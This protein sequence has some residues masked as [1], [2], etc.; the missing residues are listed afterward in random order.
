MS[1][2]TLKDLKHIPGSNGLPFL[3]Q[4]I[5][6]V[7]NATKF[8]SDQQKRHGD[9]FKY[10]TPMGTAVVLLGPT[11]NKYVLVEQ[12]KFA[13]NKEAWEQS[14][15]DLFPNG[16]ML[17]DGDKH[18]SHRSI[19]NEAFKKDPMQGYLKMMPEIIDRELVHLNGKSKALMF[20]FFKEFT[21]KMAAAIFFGLD[22][23]EDLKGIN[24][25]LTDIVNAAAVLP[26]NLPG[27]AYRKGLN[28]RKYLVSYFTS[29]IG[30]R[31][32]NP[33]S[34][35]FSRFCEA[36]SEEGETFTDQEIIDHLIFVLMAAHDT[37][38]I[39][40]SLMSYFL[41]KHPDWQDKVREDANS[42]DLFDELYVNDLRQ[43]E[44]TGY[45]MKETLRIHPPLTM[46]SRKLEKELTVEGYRIPQ[47]TLVNVVFQMT[48]KDQ[49]VW[50]N[51]ELFDPLR[52]NK[53][54][55]EH[56]VCPFAYAPFGAGKHHC[57]GY[58]FAEMQVKLVITELVKRFQLSVPDN[59]ICPIQDVPLKNP[60]DNLPMFLKTIS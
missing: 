30:E 6:F 60:K 37:T 2:S 35:L 7:T 26:I 39:T 51:P 14:L 28:G 27:T 10:S 49:R 43:L 33:G 47:N 45:V 41:A 55:R 15:S 54:R 31:R 52:F 9:V 40:L 42:F 23:N 25:A 17:M 56:S 12:A 16:L 11:A 1:L 59:Y 18:H 50:T 34:D 8:W 13:T 38:A 57:I 24:K 44:N 21:L 3:G 22:L 5:P 53:E 20:P 58:G 29:I 19:M 4:F 46:V 36:K 48:Q 32:T